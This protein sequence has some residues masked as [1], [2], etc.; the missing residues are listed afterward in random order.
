MVNF[1]KK[2]VMFVSESVLLFYKINK[3]IHVRN[4]FNN[5]FCK[6]KIYK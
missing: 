4:N 6:K 5:A 3:K 1:A 2:K